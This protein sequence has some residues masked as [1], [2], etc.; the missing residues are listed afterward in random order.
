[1]LL[2]DDDRDSSE[3]LSDFLSTEG[4][5]IQCAVNG[6][7]VLGL[8][9][10]HQ[11]R[12]ELILLDLAMP[13]LDG[14]GFLAERRKDPQLADIPVVI[15]TSSPDAT[16]KAKQ[17]GAVA[18]LRKPVDPQTLLRIIDHFAERA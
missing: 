3:A 10:N 17:A 18:V 7:E 15:V 2:V 4:F 14:W 8:L 1:M 11:Y 13:V 9:A 16:Q 6:Q 5:E 12:P